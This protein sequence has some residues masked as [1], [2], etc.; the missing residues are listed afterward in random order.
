[1]DKIEHFLNAK[2]IA[3]I[4]NAGSGKSTLT[5]QLHTIL[6]L[7]VYHLDQYFWGP[8]WQ[9]PD[10]AEYKKIHDGLCDRSEW[11]MDGVNLRLLEYRIQKS[12]V[13]IF[14]D[15][16]IY[17]CLFRVLKRSVKYY[18]QEMADNAAGCKQQLNSKFVQ[19]MKWI[20][21][22]NKEY[23]P[24]IIKLLDEY[25][26]SKSIYILRSADEVEQFIRRIKVL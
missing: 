23:K 10:P 18:N 25:K 1:M 4:G 21:N 3:V 9:H 14:L 11:I 15:I 6:G 20:L 13:I 7:A 19:F 26:N 12:D 22:F 2:R 16:S 8:N 24:R 17:T 5:K